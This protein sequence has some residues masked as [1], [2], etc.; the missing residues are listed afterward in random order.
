MHYACIFGEEM[1]CCVINPYRKFQHCLNFEELETKLR[2]EVEQG[3]R[4]LQ[5]MVNNLVTENMDLKRCIQLTEQ[6]L[7][8]LEKLIREALES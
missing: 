2:A 6:K 7:D 8:E 3:N 5:V 4:Q 1:V